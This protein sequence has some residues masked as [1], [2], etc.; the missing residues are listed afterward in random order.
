M[1]KTVYI[2]AFDI[3]YHSMPDLRHSCQGPPQ[4]SL[5]LRSLLSHN[6]G[7]ALTFRPANTLGATSNLCSEELVGKCRWLPFWTMLGG[8][9][10]LSF[11]RSSALITANLKTYL[12]LPLSSYFNLSLSF[13]FPAIPLK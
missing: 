10:L 11:Q 8:S 13:W 7:T 6:I 3:L 5:E 9:M 2:D 1:E 12:L 4:A